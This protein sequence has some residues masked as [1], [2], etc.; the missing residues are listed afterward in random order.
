[1]A[2]RVSLLST[3]YFA[4]HSRNYTD[5][6]K[7][8]QQRALSSLTLKSSLSS[9]LY[10]GDGGGKTITLTELRVLTL[11]SCSFPK[12]GIN[13]DA[14]RWGGSPGAHQRGWPLF[15]PMDPSVFQDK[16]ICSLL[17]LWAS[18]EDKLNCCATNQM[19]PMGLKADENWAQ[20]QVREATGISG[21]TCDE[22]GLL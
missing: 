8:H 11:N 17:L 3:W 1:M 13:T 5:V 19:P 14:A 20:L 4:E 12:G 15:A 7:R 16:V 22:W 6:I 2:T 9:F 21:R 10:N 18:R